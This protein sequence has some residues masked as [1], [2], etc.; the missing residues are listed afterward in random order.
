MAFD[1]SKAAF[2]K[3]AVSNLDKIKMIPLEKVLTNPDNFYSIDGIAELADSIEMVG[4]L[5]PVSVVPEATGYKLISGHRRFQAYRYLQQNDS[6][7]N[8]IPAIVL[9]GLDDLTETMAL[10]TANSTTRELT[11][12]EKCQQEKVLRDTLMAMKSIGVEIPGNL[13]QYIADQLGVS[14]N[15]V[16]RMHSVNEN[17]SDEGKAKLEAGELTAQQAYEMSRRP[18][19][20]QQ[21][22]PGK[23][24]STGLDEAQR[25][26]LDKFFE[27]YGY[28]LAV[29]ATR[30]N[31]GLKSDAINGLKF[32]LHAIGG[33]FN[34]I[35][36]TGCAKNV[37]LKSYNGDFETFSISYTDLYNELARYAI[38]RLKYDDADN[39]SDILAPVEDGGSSE[40]RSTTEWHTGT[41]EN[42]GQYVCRVRWTPKSEKTFARVLYLADGEWSLAG[43]KATTVGDQ[44]EIVNWIKLPEWW[45]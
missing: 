45:E 16:S 27:R 21:A 5:S 40:A 32:G 31:G 17:L 7:Y 1:L 34:H 6:K 3:S 29:D 18:K 12:A 20:E 15:E 42:D 19:A 25:E 43:S 39:F 36:W 30:F 2:G 26:G 22:A 14:R 38:D 28:K 9:S 24:Q 10:I 33:V 44:A 4:L 41:P 13:G 35:G 23:T 37:V 11:Y 8:S